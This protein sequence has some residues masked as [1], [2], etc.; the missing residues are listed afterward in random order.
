MEENCPVA[1]VLGIIGKKWTLRILY[2]IKN[3]KAIRFGE[4]M[5]ASHGLS[6]RTLAKRLVELEKNKLIK[7]H[8]YHEIPPKVEYS[9]TKEGLGLMNSFDDISKWA[10]NW[11]K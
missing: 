9:L 4:L 6:A 5:T 8:S 2:E 3:K 10:I 1:K 7:R 11:K